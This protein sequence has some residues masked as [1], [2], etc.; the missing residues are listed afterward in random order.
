[1]PEMIYLI[2]WILLRSDPINPVDPAAAP[3]S[4]A[5]SSSGPRGQSKKFLVEIIRPIYHVVFN[6]HYDRVAIKYDRKDNNKPLDDKK[7]R[8]GY[9]TYLPAD[10]ANYD[11]WNEL[12]MDIDRLL[13]PLGFLRD[14]QPNR[15][16]GQCTGTKY[17]A[18]RR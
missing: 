7:L 13:E 4:G 14:I 16:Y 17:F 8:K 1:M 12:V 3:E 11:D 5:V 9:D 6:E 18:M 15:L 10:S 2:T